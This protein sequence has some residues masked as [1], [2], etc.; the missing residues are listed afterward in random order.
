MK[1]SNSNTVIKLEALI[2][3]ITTAENAGKVPAIR[4]ANANLIRFY[5]DCIAKKSINSVM[6]AKYIVK[7]YKTGANVKKEVVFPNGKTH[8]GKAKFFEYDS[9]TNVISKY[10]IYTENGV[11]CTSSC[12]EEIDLTEFK[13]SL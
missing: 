1:N 12:L 2:K 10:D 7:K 3:A 6:P 11:K 9:E 8:T 4:T 13:A 5:F